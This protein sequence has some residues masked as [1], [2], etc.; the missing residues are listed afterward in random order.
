MHETND[1]HD[2]HAIITARDSATE[3]VPFTTKSAVVPTQ[4]DFGPQI[5][6]ESLARYASDQAAA[7][8]EQPEPEPEPEQPDPNQRCFPWGP[9]AQIDPLADTVTDGHAIDGGAK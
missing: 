8:A 6:A 7:S 3:R 1:M 5:I 2:P 9:G 4:Y